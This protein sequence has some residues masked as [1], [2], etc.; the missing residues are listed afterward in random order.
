MTRRNAR[1]DTQ[2]TLDTFS[3]CV[4]YEWR[5]VNGSLLAVEGLSSPDG[6]ILGKMGHSE[7]IGKYLYKN[8]LPYKKK[9]TTGP[10]LLV[11]FLMMANPCFIDSSGPI[12]LRQW[13]GEFPPPAAISRS[14]WETV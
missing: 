14:Q 11:H 2:F 6:R 12:S 3:A 1:D 8:V 4:Y 5:C 9:C 13:P 10:G 7:R